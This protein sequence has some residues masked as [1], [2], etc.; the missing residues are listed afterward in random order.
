MKTKIV[1]ITGAERLSLDEAQLT[2]EVIEKGGLI[3]F[4]TET[5]YGLGCAADHSS[6]IAR[7]YQ[8]K[9]RNRA[10]PLA[11]HLG[12]VEDLLQ[13]ASVSEREWQLITQLVPGPYTLIL[14]ATGDAPPVAVSEGKVGIRVPRSPAFQMVAEA[15]GK[16]L[17]GTSANRGGEE[18]AI[19]P[20]EA[21]DRFAPQVDLIIVSSKLPSGRS[22]SVID[23]TEDPPRALRGRLPKFI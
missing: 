2:A 5:V 17:A 15:S 7:L 13:Y 23:L 11:L 19:T 4:P 10:K 18:P 20:E 12:R 22:S 21:I 9:Q 6:A 14:R 3:L 8:L 1:E 16:P